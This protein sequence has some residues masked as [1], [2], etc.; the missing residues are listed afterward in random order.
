M[1]AL[2]I[3]AEDYP[4]VLPTKNSFLDGLAFGGS[5]YPEEQ[6]SRRHGGQEKTPER[7]VPYLALTNRLTEVVDF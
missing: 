3:P 7:R 5:F 2:R 6:I 1:S 4:T